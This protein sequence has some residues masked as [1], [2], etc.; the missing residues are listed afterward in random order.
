MISGKREQIELPGGQAYRLLRWA[1][2][3]R[4]VE[5]VLSPWRGV[6]VDGEGDHWHYHQACELTL[7]SA[8]EGTRFVGDSIAAFHRGDLVL[9][10]E[11]LPHYWH[12]PGIST[13]LA[14]QWSFPPSHP[15]WAFPEAQPLT[16]YLKSAA[17]GIHF[18]GPTASKLTA[19]LHQLTGTVAL[20][21]LGVLLRILATAAAAPERDYEYLSTRAFSLSAEAGHQ[22]AMRAA[23]QFLVAHFRDEVRME[24]LL[25][26]THMSK[27]TFCRQ[28]KAHS[29]KTLNEFLQHIRL[30]A[31]CREL[32]ET[33]H[34][35]TDVALAS[36]FSQISF[37]NRVFRRT[38]QCSP[39]EYR[40]RHRHEK[41]A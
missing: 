35:I 2:N 24:Q 38:Y 8:G 34:A 16:A 26:V 17:R 36:G 27:A 28:F 37:F 12:S 29:G 20:E 30:D 9:L 5:H 19:L 22:A 39:G 23:V 6:R 21:R 10:G 33:D 15:L 4:D 32:A 18:R 11:N 1:E 40:E 13:G 31:V 14:V 7:F 41:S 3:L 25:A